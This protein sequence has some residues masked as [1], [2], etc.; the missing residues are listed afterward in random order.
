MTIDFSSLLPVEERRE[1]LN[2]RIEQ[3]AAE[4]YQHHLNRLAA[5]RNNKPELVTEADTAMREL[6]IVIET[7]Q[8][9]LN[10]LPPV[11]R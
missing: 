1:V 2:K 11:K 5:Q 7:Y 4:G 8:Q 3:L 9:E 10:S 6:S